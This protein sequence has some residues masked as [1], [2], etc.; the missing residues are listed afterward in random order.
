MKQY[1]ADVQRRIKEAESRLTTSGEFEFPVL[2]DMD[3]S[4]VSQTF[5]RKDFGRGIPPSLQWVI[6]QSRISQ[7]AR[8]YI[9]YAVEGKHSTIQK[10]LG[11]HQEKRLLPAKV[12]VKEASS[13][14]GLTRSYVVEI[15]PQ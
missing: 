6:P 13:T 10:K 2:V 1:P 5:L 3:G 8:P 14:D 7:I 12:V 15:K 4:I 11:L 9:P